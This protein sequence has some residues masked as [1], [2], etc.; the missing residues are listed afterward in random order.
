MFG[1]FGLCLL[2]CEVVVVCCCVLWCWCVCGL[3]CFLL[4][5]CFV[6]GLWLVEYWFGFGCKALGWV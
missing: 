5:G 2:C 4:V 6:G 1:V 3:I